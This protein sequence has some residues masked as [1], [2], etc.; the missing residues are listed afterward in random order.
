MDL[1]PATERRNHGGRAPRTPRCT[2]VGESSY[3]WV[4]LDTFRPQSTGAVRFATAAGAR[5]GR[6]PGPLP[7][8][9]LEEHER[10]DAGCGVGGV[11]GA[12]LR[13]ADVNA[14][15]VTVRAWTLSLR[16]AIGELAAARLSWYLLCG[17][18]GLWG[19]RPLCPSMP[20]TF[21][22]ADQL[23]C[24]RRRAVAAARW[25]G[26]GAA[27]GSSP[28]DRRGRP[29]GDRAGPGPP[30][31]AGPPGLPCPRGP[32]TAGPSLPQPGLRRRQQ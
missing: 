17:R 11:R 32:A 8:M 5:C 27:P 1:H 19:W 28:D 12:R 4:R 7:W 25:R 16:A 20:I 15:R 24:R 26:A 29:V 18:V 13:G 9:R 3:G 6:V 2:T 23:S 21:V 10:V 22:C 30:A 14:A 31:G